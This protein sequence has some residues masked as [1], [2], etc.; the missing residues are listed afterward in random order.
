MMKKTG[1]FCALLLALALGVPAPPA[2]T[3]SDE[4]TIDD[5]LLGKQLCGPTVTEE[6]CR[7]RVT[8]FFVWGIT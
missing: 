8:L 5:V 2:V 7:D 3:R 1:A 6:D 4:T